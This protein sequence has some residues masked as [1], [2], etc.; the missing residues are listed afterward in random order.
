MEELLQDPSDGTIFRGKANREASF[1][2]QI[3]LFLLSFLLVLVYSF[4]SYIQ[5]VISVT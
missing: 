2:I 4:I 1:S 5:I 3:S